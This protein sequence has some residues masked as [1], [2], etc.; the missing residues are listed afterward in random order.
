MQVPKSGSHQDVQP[1][2]HIKILN[3]HLWLWYMSFMATK[4]TDLTELVPMNPV[5][6]T[7]STEPPWYCPQTK[8]DWIS[9][10][11]DFHSSSRTRTAPGSGVQSGFHES[12]PHAFGYKQKRLFRR[13]WQAWTQT[14]RT[15]CKPQRL[16][17]LSGVRR[18]C[19]RDNLRVQ[20][21]ALFV[22]VFF[23]SP[24]HPI[25]AWH[26]VNQGHEPTAEGAEW[27]IKRM[28]SWKIYFLPPSFSFLSVST[29]SILHSHLFHYFHHSSFSH[30]ILTTS[31]HPEI[32]NPLH[33]IS[34]SVFSSYFH[35]RILKAWLR[36][37]IAT[38]LLRLQLL[39]LIQ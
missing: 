11:S 22:F 37:T 18:K 9:F 1:S 24:L 12:L 34:L 38:A 31:S 15:D 33:K 27:N 2:S 23:V 7:L 30:A 28:S 8:V 35:P 14:N 26:G 16:F 20:F 32:S 21:N 3:K 36:R 29:V 17:T 19:C 39:R 6:F 25:M 10:S 13:P 5:F 4:L